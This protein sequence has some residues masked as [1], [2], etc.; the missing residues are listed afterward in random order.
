MTLN[1]DKV[2]TAID[3]EYVKHNSFVNLNIKNSK[4][5]ED[6][7]K[8]RI[9][10]S[11]KNEKNNKD[12]GKYRSEI[13]DTVYK[14]LF[15]TSESKLSHRFKLTPNVIAEIETLEDRE[16]PKYLFHRYRYEIFPKINKSDDYPPYL[17]IEPSSI[18]NYRC[19][20]CFETD[21]TFTNKKNGHMGTIELSLFKKIIDEAEN[22]I[23]FMSL[24]SR[25]E[26]LISKNIIPMLKYTENKF[27]NLKINTNASLLTEEISHAI[28][29][30]TVKTLVFSADAADPELYKKLRV[31][32]SLKKILKN[33]EMFN[34]IKEKQY[35]NSK[36]I[37][38]VSGVK[39]NNEQNF[40]SMKKLWGSLV[41][42]VAFV[43]YNPWESV[44]TSPKNEIKKPCSDL[45]RRMFIWWDGKVNPCDTDYKSILSKDNFPSISLKKIWKGENFNRLR[46]MHLNNKRQSI[47]PCKSCT[48]I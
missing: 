42:Q 3:K 43:D 30:D 44:Y 46:E 45:W 29:S 36:I 8:D 47:F 40:D 9:K 34:N 27:L 39:V 41:D 13:V 32:G 25:G 28:L 48:L 18:C 24:A 20:F 7:V 31:N 37:T 2:D 5:D 17:Q 4:K 16:I 10:L 23:E 35:S 38:R 26:P 22:N 6:L 1:K 15:N 11:I 21:S 19:V 12:L 33:I 14:D